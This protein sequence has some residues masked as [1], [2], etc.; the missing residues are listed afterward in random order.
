MA[1]EPLLNKPSEYAP[2]SSDSQ[3]TYRISQS[4]NNKHGYQP[5]DQQPQQY[6]PGNQQYQPGNQQ[7]QPMNQ[8]QYQPGDQ[9]QF[10]YQSQPSYQQPQPSYQQSQPGNN[11]NQQFS[12]SN[13]VS[14]SQTSAP[15][16]TTFHPVVH[17]TH[18]PVIEQQKQPTVIGFSSCEMYCPTCCILVKS[19]VQYKSGVLA[20]LFALILF[21]LGLWILC[22]LPCLFNGLKDAHH[23][24]PR[25]KKKFY[26]L[27]QEFNA[28]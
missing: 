10:S 13:S 19:Q 20:Y 28:T 27:K 24:C 26:L 8:Q 11:P 3:S 18:G 21:I 22:C 5:L 15:Q 2:P 6:Q 16:D 14:Y 25:C 7:Y 9:S 4:Y 23:H 12:H 1:A 17:P